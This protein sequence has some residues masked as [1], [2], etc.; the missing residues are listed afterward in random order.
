MREHLLPI[1]S[2]IRKTHDRPRVYRVWRL[3]DWIHFLFVFWIILIYFL[4]YSGLLKQIRIIIKTKCI[5]KHIKT[6][7]IRWLFENSKHYIFSINDFH[8]RV[9]CGQVH[10]ISAAI[11]FKDKGKNS[12]VFWLIVFYRRRTLHAPLTFPIYNN[13]I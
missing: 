8:G 3:T 5:L 6:I 7:F 10:F 11:T 13:L 12:I 1:Q 4:L 9:S 2:W